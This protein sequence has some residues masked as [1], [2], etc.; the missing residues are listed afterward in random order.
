MGRNGRVEDLR[1]MILNLKKE[2]LK[3]YNA[4][5]NLK[6]KLPMVTVHGRFQPPLHINHWNYIAPAFEIAEKVRIL[7]TNPYRKSAVVKEAVH[8]GKKENNPFSYSQRVKIFIKY[9][10]TCQKL[11][12]SNFLS[13]QRPVHVPFKVTSS[14]GVT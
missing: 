14:I 4:K 7:I 10:A 6:K 11:N 2:Q 9:P 12:L 8:R 1:F 5:L 13:S 3:V